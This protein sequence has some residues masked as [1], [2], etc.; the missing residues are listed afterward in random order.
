[1]NASRVGP[2]AWSLMG[3]WLGTRWLFLL[4]A[5]AAAALALVR[6]ELHG[7]A[8]HGDSVSYIAAARNLTA[9][10]GYT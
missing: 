4:L 9:G 10:I 6:T 1:M 2:R 7:I 8:L 5:L 3:M